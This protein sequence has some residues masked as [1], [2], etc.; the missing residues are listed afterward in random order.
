[1]NELT[2][3]E[4]AEKLSRYVK[5]GFTI[6]GIAFVILVVLVLVCWKF[7][8]LKEKSVLIIFALFIIL[9]V[10]VYF[11]SVFPYQLDIK[12]QSYKKYMGEFYVEDYYKTSRSVSEYILIK[13][14]NENYST[15]YKIHESYIEIEPNTVYDGSFVYAEKSKTIVEIKMKQNENIAKTGD[16]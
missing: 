5:I 3:F 1:M 16:G 15:K 4:Y 12:Q 13:L 2:L 7:E 9:I 8:C 10:T 14:P 11:T 6:M